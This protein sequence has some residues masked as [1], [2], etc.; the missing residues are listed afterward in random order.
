MSHS[1]D[2]RTGEQPDRNLPDPSSQVT[3]PIYAEIPD[4]ESMDPIYT[5]VGVATGKYTYN[6][7]TNSSYDT[8]MLQNMNTNVCYGIAT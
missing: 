3:G 6:T 7:T 8:V 4:E 1:D 2:G 5:S